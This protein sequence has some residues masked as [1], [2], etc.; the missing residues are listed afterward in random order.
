MEALRKGVERLEVERAQ[1]QDA[2]ETDV[3]RAAAVGED[4]QIP[5]RRSILFS[6]SLKT[7]TRLSSSYRRCHWKSGAEVIFPILHRHLTYAS[8]R[9]WKLYT[10]RALYFCSEAWRREYGQSVLQAHKEMG[11]E[12]ELV[13]YR[14]E[15]LDDLTMQGWCKV[16]TVDELTQE[17]VEFYRGPQGQL[18]SNIQ[19]VFD[20]DQAIHRL[21]KGASTEFDPGAPSAACVVQED[22]G[23]SCGW[24]AHESASVPGDW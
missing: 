24:D 14:R 21:K 12:D 20:Q 15:G 22:N 7:L 10:K 16:K 3:K 11:A 18:C 17:P 6:E 5:S 2:R 19:E 4:P 1:R 8:H 9:T 23:Q 13:V